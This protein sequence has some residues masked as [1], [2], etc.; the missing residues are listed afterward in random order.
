[1]D[2]NIAEASARPETN[3]VAAFLAPS[4]IEVSSNSVK[5]NAKFSRTF[6]ILE[7]PRYLSSGWFSPIINL[8]GLTDIA[9]HINPT[10]TGIALKGLRKKAAQVESQL[11]DAQQK[12]QV[13]DPMLETAFSDIE[14]LRDSLQQAREKLFNV[15]VYIT[16]YGDSPDELNKLENEVKNILDSKL[17]VVKPA[18]FEHLNG[19]IS[20]LPLGMDK[21][22]IH[23]PLNSQPVSSFFPFVSLDLTSDK[24]ILYGINRHNNTLVIFDR[25]SLENA[26]MVIFAKSGSGKSYTTKLEIIRSLMVGTDIIVI[27]PENEYLTLA[28]SVGGT[29]LKIS[30]DSKSHINPFDIPIVP[31]DEEPGEVLKSHIINLTGLIKL[32]LGA[33]SAEEEAL[34][35]RAITE[36]YASR[37]ITPDKDFRGTPAPLLSD[38]RTILEGMEGGK[39]MASRLY[40]FTEGSYS[41]F[42]NQPTNINVKNRLIVFSIRDLEDEL[43]PI[44]MF[45]ILNFIWNLIRSEL[46]KRIMIIDEAWWMMKYPDSAIFLYGLVK[47]SRKYY[48]GITTITQDVE[49]FL[50]SQYGRPI[51]TN[52]SIQLLLKQAPATAES[53]MKAFNL[54]E[55]EKN[56]LLEA[57]VGQGLFIAGLKR[58]AIQIVPSYFE[59]K[60]ITTNPEQILNIKKAEENK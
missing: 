46:K 42:V 17:I 44:A 14:N 9:I 23:A 31:E 6:F 10:D 45:I 49:D 51:I 21:L 60:L 50:N 43:R 24:G 48:L 26:N 33:I 35:D 54:T 36:T 37:D 18:A 5:I 34:L 28:Q 3:D 41:G 13:R 40:R 58:A 53:T 30:L 12:G 32:M 39:D 56:Y 11:S 16:I 57:G 20:V 4:S 27:D 25:F 19:F 1:M 55:T 22:N 47:R 7:Y 52:S 29:V 8:T 2:R 15:G 38:F 59:D